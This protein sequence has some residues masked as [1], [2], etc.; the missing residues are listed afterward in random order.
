MV[1][2]T[3][4]ALAGVALLYIVIGVGLYLLYPGVAGEILHELG[5]GFVPVLTRLAMVLVVIF[6]T[7]LLI[8]PCSELVEGKLDLHPDHDVVSTPLV[9]VRLGIVTVA[10][11]I[12]VLL[13]GFV[14]VLSF[15]GCAC[16]GLVGFCLPPILHMRLLLR[17]RNDAMPYRTKKNLLLVDGLMIAWGVFATIVSSV[18]TFSKL[19][20]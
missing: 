8:L 11:F 20:E 14:Q 9:L 19:L 17:I 3:T 12:A 7:P 2:A 1:G 10:G 4:I 18:Y 16:V 13:P 15:V 5:D 6:T